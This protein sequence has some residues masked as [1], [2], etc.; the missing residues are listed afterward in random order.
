MATMRPS[1][2]PASAA[3]LLQIARAIP[4]FW[5]CVFNSGPGRAQSAP[6]PWSSTVS[7]VQSLEGAGNAALALPLD[8]SSAMKATAQAIQKASLVNS[9]AGGHPPAST[10]V[11]PT[12]QAASAIAAAA[13]AIRKVESDIR[14][15]ADL[16]TA[17]AEALNW[18]ANGG[19]GDEPAA[20]SVID[21]LLKRGAES[22]RALAERLGVNFEP[23]AGGPAFAGAAMA[24]LAV[25][26]QWAAAGDAWQARAEVWNRGAEALDAA[27]Q[28]AAAN[29]AVARATQ[30]NGWGTPSSQAEMQ[31]FFPVFFDLMPPGSTVSPN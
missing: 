23:S 19:R 1:F 4:V 12:Y 10:L 7:L 9:V 5:L 17:S 22:M 16:F 31:D 14:K 8:Q 24:L 3:R 6:S 29:G 11:G 15:L 25:A 13:R 26:N 2:P 28:Q 20:A 27:V 30:G 18:L 21:S